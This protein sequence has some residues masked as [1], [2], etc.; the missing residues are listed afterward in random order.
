M[1]SWV[2]LQ[3]NGLIFD[4]IHVSSRYSLIATL[5][6]SQNSALSLS[7]CNYSSSL[8][9][10]YLLVAA[11][12]GRNEGKVQV[13]VMVITRDCSREFVIV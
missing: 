8:L 10:L 11:A 7:S 13:I 5:T 6:G 2:R 4:F 12:R 3:D 9:P 1:S